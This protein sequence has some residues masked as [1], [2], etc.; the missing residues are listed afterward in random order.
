MTAGVCLILLVVVG[1]LT[2]FRQGSRSRSQSGGNWI[3][4]I[5]RLSHA[6][7]LSASHKILVL[8]K[9]SR[10]DPVLDFVM[11][12]VYLFDLASQQ[13]RWLTMRQASVAENISN[14]NTPGFKAGDVAPF[15]EIFDG[16]ALQMAA[17][18]RNHLG[19]GS[20]DAAGAPIANGTPWEVSYSGNSVS[21]EQ[22]M[23]K[24]G[25]VY[26]AYSMNTSIVKAFN[27]M[28]MASLKG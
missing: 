5:F 4:L 15:N 26:R 12:Q 20:S 19:A 8:D 17:T 9:F 11:Q 28:M 24:S 14:A 7:K 21:I 10:P 16:T 3:S 23:I 2:L 6:P 1:G 27:D 25:E 18:D 22:E 13:A